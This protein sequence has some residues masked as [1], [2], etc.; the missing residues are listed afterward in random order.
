M[1]NIRERVTAKAHTRA[2]TNTLTWLKC[3]NILIKKSKGK[4]DARE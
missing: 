3:K 1:L 2:Q 4:H